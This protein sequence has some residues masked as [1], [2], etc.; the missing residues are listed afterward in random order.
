MKFP[1]PQKFLPRAAFTLI[2]LIV[3]IAILLLLMVLFLTIFTNMS[4]SFGFA[5]G[6]MDTFEE[7]R[8]TSLLIQRELSEA[9]VRQWDTGGQLTQTEDN[10]NIPFL[11]D[12]EGTNL[13][14]RNISFVAYDEN[15]QEVRNLS[16]LSHFSYFWVR[17]EAAVYRSVANTKPATGARTEQER[18]R[19]LNRV[20]SN[21][22]SAD[23]EANLQRLTIM[24]PTYLRRENWIND[25][26]P[27]NSRLDVYDPRNNVNEPIMTKVFDFDIETFPADTGPFE[28][29]DLLIIRLGIADRSQV[30]E[31]RAVVENDEE[32]SEEQK[33]RLRYFAITVPMRNRN[34]PMNDYWVP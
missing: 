30:P 31:F 20:S 4:R 21:P 9:V 12:A 25:R 8:S 19:V 15:L 27:L 26:L 18:L 10:R 14:D 23:T 32:L 7:I 29:P 11:V 22:N 17:K 16:I 3:S 2:E 24:T 1:Q 33:D 13:G 28:L 6:A 5:R 34:A